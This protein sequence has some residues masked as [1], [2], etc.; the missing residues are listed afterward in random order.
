VQDFPSQLFN[1]PNSNMSST[2]QCQVYAT[3]LLADI[4][5]AANNAIPRREDVV[6]WL[7][8]FLHRCDVKGY[9]AVP[10]DVENLVALDEFVRANQI[11]FTIRVTP[12]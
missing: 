8:D 4:R 12:V 9:H 1:L 11:P 6:A 3:S 7:S 10:A 5:A 2:V